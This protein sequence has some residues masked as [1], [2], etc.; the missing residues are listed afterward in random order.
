MKSDI[1][2]AVSYTHLLGTVLIT[3]LP[4][5]LKPLQEYIRLV[6]GLG[7]MLLMVFMPMGLWG[8]ITGW[9]KKFKQKFKLGHKT[10]VGTESKEG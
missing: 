3:M 2:I 5:W 8:L 6:Y 7:V 1:L 10:V 9:V 4:E